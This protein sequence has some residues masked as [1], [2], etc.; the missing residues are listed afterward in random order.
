[1]SLRR[2]PGCLATTLGLV[3]L[4]L[5]IVYGVAAITSPWAFH[6]GG[7]STP[8]LYWSGYGKLVAK[9][10]T[11]PLY[12]LLY[13]SSHF[14]RLHLDG[15][16][17]TGGVQGSGWLCTSP[18]VVQR[19]HLSGTLF[20]GWTSTEG[21]LLDFRLNERKIFDVGQRQGFFD[22]YGRWHGQQLVMD[23]RGRVGGVF[24]SNLKVEQASIVLDW[25]S[26]SEFKA[27]CDR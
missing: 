18:G 6:I 7:R 10:G 24:Q 2:R 26:Y 11:Y 15:M 5:A 23:E 20:G 12:V 16:R 27:M 1:M 17:P 4:C 9:S 14:S 8:L 13:P 3:V 19:L 21:A 25:G 22:L